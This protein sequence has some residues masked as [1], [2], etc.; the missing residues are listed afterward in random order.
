MT[1][2]TAAQIDYLGSQLLGRLATTGTDHKPHVVPTSFRYNA[3]LGTV[4][5]GGHHMAGTKK[6]RDVR[7]NGWAAIVVDDL[8]TTH[9][10]TPRMLEIRGRAE[11]VPTGGGHLGP[12]FGEAF[13]RIHPERVNSFGIE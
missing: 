9:P 12:G 1:E 4:D 8:V 10:W 3:D 6:Y 5:V 13:I 11:A 2:L 7:A